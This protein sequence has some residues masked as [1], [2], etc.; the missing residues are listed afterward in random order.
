MQINAVQGDALS[1][2]A[3]AIFRALAPTVRAA[4]EAAGINIVEREGALLDPD[5]LSRALKA[6]GVDPVKRMEIKRSI[7]RAAAGV[8]A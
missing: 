5:A 8:P 4:L 6:A 2:R 7:E 3:A 1:L